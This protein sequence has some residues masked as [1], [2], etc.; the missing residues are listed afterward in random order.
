MSATGSTATPLTLK[1]VY[2]HAPEVNMIYANYNN[3]GLLKMHCSGVHFIISFFYGLKFE[4][5]HPWGGK[6]KNKQQQRKD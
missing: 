6:N 2:L 4:S 1:Y 3:L 5:E